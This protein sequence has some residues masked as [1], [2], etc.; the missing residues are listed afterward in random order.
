M[1]DDKHSWAVFYNGKPIY[2]GLSRKMAKWYKSHE[3]KKE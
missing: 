1:G 3:E 2:T